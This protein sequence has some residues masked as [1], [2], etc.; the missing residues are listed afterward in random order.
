MFGG[1][2]SLP[3]R[4]PNPAPGYL[5]LESTFLYTHLFC[6][7]VDFHQVLKS[8]K[9]RLQSFLSFLK[10]YV[11]GNITGVPLGLDESSMGILLHKS[12]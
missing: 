10:F 7:K 4:P 11:M 5:V 9:L 6:K 1:S 2:N 3:P 12:D 8:D